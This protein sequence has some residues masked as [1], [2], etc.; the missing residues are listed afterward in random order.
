MPSAEPEDHWRGWDQE[1]TPAGM[2]QRQEQ[3]ISF[4]S[5]LHTASLVDTQIIDC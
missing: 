1:K 4:A 5:G 2:L 3:S